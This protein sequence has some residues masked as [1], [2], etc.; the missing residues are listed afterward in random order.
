MTENK[1]I[2]IVGG[3]IAGLAAAQAAREASAEAQITMVLQEPQLPYYRTRLCEVI[4]G[5]AA[6]KLSIH[7]QIWYTAKRRRFLP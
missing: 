1:R 4:S 2:V 5:L 6:E 3:G 7:P